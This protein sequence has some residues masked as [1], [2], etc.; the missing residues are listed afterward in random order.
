MKLESLT[1][2]SI[3]VIAC[4]SGGAVGTGSSPIARWLQWQTIDCRNSL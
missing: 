1:K 3:R 2:E 4:S